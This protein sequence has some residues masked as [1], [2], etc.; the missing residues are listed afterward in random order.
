MKDEERRE[1]S[2]YDLELVAGGALSDA[3]IEAYL[4]GF[5]DASVRRAW[6]V[7]IGILYN[8][9]GW[10][11]NRYKGI[12]VELAAWAIDYGGLTI[13]QKE[14]ENIMLQAYEKFYRKIFSKY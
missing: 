11:F 13:G 2:F 4:E 10:D 3:E 7:A 5:G 9:K 8:Y 14:F 12:V 1:L 6:E